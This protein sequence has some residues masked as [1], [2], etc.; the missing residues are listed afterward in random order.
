MRGALVEGGV[1]TAVYMLDEN[2][3]EGDWIECPDNTSVG[4]L[5]DGTTFSPPPDVPAEIV[6]PNGTPIGP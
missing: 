3:G 2:S 1:V 6:D 4:W 5:Y